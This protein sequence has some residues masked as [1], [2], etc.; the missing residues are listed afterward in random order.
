MYK[1][2]FSAEYTQTDTHPYGIPLREV[3][4]PRECAF[5]FY[6]TFYASLNLEIPLDNLFLIN[7]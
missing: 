5:V 4:H 1:Y 6:T 2:S 3:L 7:S